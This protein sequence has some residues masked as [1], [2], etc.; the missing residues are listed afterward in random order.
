MNLLRESSRPRQIQLI[1]EFA[2]E[3]NPEI[4]KT[5]WWFNA[6]HNQFIPDGDWRV[7]LALAGRGFGKTR[8][9]AET[10]RMWVKDNDYVNLMGAT[11]ADARDIMVEGESGILAC[12]P[13][14]E[15]PE[16]IANKNLLRW[17]NGARSLIWTADKPERMR[18]KQSAKIW[19]DELASWRYPESYDQAMLGL[20][21]GKRPQVFVST[22]PRPIKIIKELVKN[23]TTFVTRGSTYDNKANLAAQ[24][25]EQIIKKYDG[26]R[27]GRQE[28]FAEILEDNPHALWNRDRIDA[29][30]QRDVPKDLR[31]IVVAVDP[32]VSDNENSCETGIIVAGIDR[33]EHGYV[34]EDCSMHGTA[35]AW[36][37]RAVRAYHEWKADRLIGEAN[38][39]GDL[40]EALIRTKDR[41]VSY[42]KVHASRGKTKRAEPI[43]ALYEQG[44]V[45]HIGAFAQLEDQMCAW[46]PQLSDSEQDSPDRMDALVWAF[47]DLMLKPTKEFLVV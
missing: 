25:I 30:R 34:L 7:W 31:R 40:I 22:T 21:L 46:N 19:M 37:A 1:R 16:Y 32:A 8:T 43:S 4:L 23:P 44:R 24:F 18:G 6:R 36:A 35:D 29:L 17:P 5:T 3:F 33:Q 27:I 15:R 45:H 38:N 13:K 9:G 12:C 2:K 26:T 10:V 11:S 41:N 47:S 28:L 39:G 20:R 42:R 14:D